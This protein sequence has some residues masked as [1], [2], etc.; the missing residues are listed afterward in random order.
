MDELA[1]SP[2]AP[3]S[4]RRVRVWFGDHPIADHVAE[5]LQAERYEEA[6]RRRF[7]C[8]RV[9]NDPAVMPALTMAAAR[10]PEP[11]R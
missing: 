1:G 4:H 11:T 10:T 3:T 6:M 5:P 2:T 8:C 7:A 9:T